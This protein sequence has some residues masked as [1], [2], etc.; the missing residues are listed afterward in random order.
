MD[1][2]K[3]VRVVAI[4]GALL[5]ISHV[6]AADLPAKVSPIK[7]PSPTVCVQVKIGTEQTADFR[8]LNAMMQQ[9]VEKEGT[10]QAVLQAAQ[11]GVTALAPTQLGLFNVTATHERLGNAFGHSAFPQRPTPTYHVPFIH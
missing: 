6:Q 1:M 3:F 9:L 5:A 7:D 10:R 11:D 8:C 4:N 2:T